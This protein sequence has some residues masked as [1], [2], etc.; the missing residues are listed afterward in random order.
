MNESIYSLG[1]EKQGIRSLFCNHSIY[2]YGK[3]C[4]PQNFITSV[5]ALQLWSQHV[6][7]TVLSALHTL[8]CEISVVNLFV[9]N[10]TKF[11]LI[12]KLKPKTTS[13]CLP[14][15]QCATAML[16]NGFYHFV[17][18]HFSILLPALTKIWGDSGIFSSL[19][20]FL[21]F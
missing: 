5:P 16:G 18:L 15:K 13:E 21:K 6:P 1:W 3:C 2:R 17:I 4:I 19:V 10:S 11:S 14:M 12:Y 7:E 9:W 20:F 8:Y